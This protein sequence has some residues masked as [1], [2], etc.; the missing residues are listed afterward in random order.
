MRQQLLNLGLSE[1]EVE[2]YLALLEFGTQPAS[3]IARKIGLPRPTALFHCRQLFEKGYVRKTKQG[4]AQLFYVEIEDLK[5]LKHRELKKAEKSLEEVIPL[6]KEFKNPFTSQA[7]VSFFEGLEGCRRAYSLLLESKTEILEFA[8]HNDLLKMGEDFMDNF[9]A[10]RAKRKILIRP[11]CPRNET[12]LAR[13]KLDKKEHRKLKMFNPK[14]VGKIYS[15]IAIYDDKVLLL[16]LYHDP[17]GLLIESHEVAETLKT[18][19][20][21]L[22]GF[23]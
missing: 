16:N 3:V 10:E 14:K 7:K 9:I 11:I 2:V 21:M 12:H 4:K 18:L 22:W 6:L 13:L 17:F 8:P 19:H 23:L 5:T 15:S 20:R 1:K